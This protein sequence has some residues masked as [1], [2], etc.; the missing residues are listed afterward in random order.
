MPKTSSQAIITT[1]RP[2]LKRFSD[3]TVALADRGPWLVMVPHD[4]DAVLGM[5][6]AIQ[7]ARAAGVDVHIAIVSDGRMGFSKKEDRAGI[8]QLRR[9]EMEESSRI[10]GVAPDHLHWFGFPDSGLYNHQGCQTRADGS[11]TGIA[12]EMTRVMRAVRPTVVF[13]PTSAD[14][15]PDHRIVGSELAISVFHAAGAIWLEL[16]QPIAVPRRFEFAVYCPFPIPPNVEVRAEK[17]IFAKKLDSIACF[18]SQPQISS[19]VERVTAAPPVEYLLEDSWQPY[20]AS[21]YKKLFPR[22]K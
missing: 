5:G 21:M 11:I 2:K 15:H 4:D 8:V 3:I 22:G 12:W 18:A 19:L 7:C 6:L 1:R 14:L 13:A 10:I 16:G 9:R 20:D 17:P